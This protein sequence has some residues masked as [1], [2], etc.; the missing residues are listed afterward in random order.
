MDRIENQLEAVLGGRYRLIR[1]LGEGGMGS[2]YEASDA[3]LHGKRWAVKEIRPERG[4]L[5]ADMT[6]ADLMAK[7]NH[8]ML[9][10][11]VDVILP[12]HT[13]CGYVVMD[14]IEGETLQERFERMGHSMPF[15]EMIHYATQLC[16]VL[17]YLHCHRDQPIIYRDLKPSNVMINEH[18]TVQLIDFGIARSYKEGQ[19]ADTIPIGTVGFAAPEQFDGRQTDHRTDLYTLGAMIYYLLSGG[20]YYRSSL[21]PMEKLQE[22]VPR[23]FVPLLSKLLA[24]KPDDRHQNAEQLRRDLESHAHHTDDRQSKLG[25]VTTAENTALY[26]PMPRTCI[27]VA[28]TY[29]G[30]GAT[31]VA[32]SAAR[33]LNRHQIP[34]AVIE[35]CSVHPELWQL[36]FGEKRA[37]DSYRFLED[38]LNKTD[39]GTVDRWHDGAT[40]WYPRKPEGADDSIT[41]ANW[42]KLLYSLREP[43][44]IVDM[45]SQWLNQPNEQAM[46]FADEVWFVVGSDPSKL[47]P[48]RMRQ[49]MAVAQSCRE[50]GR[51][52]HWIANRYADFRGNREWLAGFPHKAAGMVPDVPYCAVVESLWSGRLIQDHPA[53]GSPVF[54]ALVPLLR[55]LIQPVQYRRKELKR[56]G[57]WWRRR[58]H[59]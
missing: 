53:N 29:P 54:E 37:P 28:S 19:P 16:D 24:E 43:I 26:T 13:G 58:G 40:T 18:N 50:S 44:L 32:I 9:P 55:P 4:S 15:Q 20:T 3:R 42:I 45:S 30:A 10:Q 12:D 41:E 7:L 51:D 49:A 1:K 38:R 5:Q 46:S 23:T 22:N 31:F 11:I 8:P 59:R 35:H 6:E 14:L 52:V 48:V 57:S 36:L 39:P 33:A 21:H 56:F 17:H 34:H 47:S 25:R 2:V 27:A